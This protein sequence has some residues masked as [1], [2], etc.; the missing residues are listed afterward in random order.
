MQLFPT[1]PV[2]VHYRPMI[3]RNV[4]RMVKLQKL[5]K[6]YNGSTFVK[7]EALGFCVPD[8]IYN[9]VHIFHHIYWHLLVG[10]MGLRQVVDLYFVFLNL[11]TDDERRKAHGVIKYLGVVKF[12]SALMWVL[13]EKLLLDEKFL[14]CAPNKKE[15]EFLWSEIMQSGN[16]RHY[17]KRLKH[18]KKIPL[19]FVIE[20]TIYTFRL[21]KHYPINTSHGHSA[22]LNLFLYYLETNNWKLTDKQIE[23]FFSMPQKPGL[24]QYATKKVREII[25]DV[26]ET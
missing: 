1:I 24:Q 25:S 16:M 18:S 5:A 22:L 7:N 2:E 21:I 14:I 19:G 20:N 10:G 11:S 9:A 13:R 26:H 8:K 17:D 12:C 15:G 4:M 23:D 6:Q 3:S